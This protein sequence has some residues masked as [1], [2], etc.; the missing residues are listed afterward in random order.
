MAKQSL[1]IRGAAIVTMN[2]EHEM[3]RDGELLIEK[4]RITS[5]GN[6]TDPPVGW[7]ASKAERIIEARGRAVLPGLVNAHNHAAMSLFRGYAD[8]LPLMEWLS[9]RIWPAEA[10][11]T[12]EDVY[13][14]TALAV[15]EMA[16]GGTTTF[17]DM[18]F[19]MDQVAEVVRKTGLR[20]VLS[21]GLTA[22]EKQDE[23]LAETRKFAGE[24]HKGA[25]GRVRVAVG[26][27]AP[28]T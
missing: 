15:L 10:R 4:G 9:K 1:L 26:P 7:R 12:P 23:A 11:L 25:G 21:R 17:A 22:G 19:H 3:I 28:Y 8:D 5:V 14:G 13:W 20:A 2:D 27:H 18:Y 6:A 16:R 24:W